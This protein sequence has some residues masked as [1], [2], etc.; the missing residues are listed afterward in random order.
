MARNWEK[1]TGKQVHYLSITDREVVLGDHWGTAMSD[2]AR[3]CSHQDFLTG[4]LQ[5]Q[6]RQIFG[7]AVLAEAL[8]EL[9]HVEAEIAPPPPQANFE[10]EKRL[11][12]AADAGDIAALRRLI[13]EGVNVNAAD[14]GGFAPLHYAMSSYPHMRDKDHLA[15][16]KTLVEAGADVNAATPNGQT[17]LY[18][19]AAEGLYETVV[20][21][22][23]RGAAVNVILDTG[24]TALLEISRKCE[25]RPL[26][27][28]VT[29]TR[30]GK[31]TTLTD[32]EAIRQAIGSHPD[33]EFLAYQKTAAY[34]IQN[35]LDVNAILHET[36]QT[37][38]FAPAGGGVT[39]IAALIL[40]SDKADV[41]H[42]DKWGLTPLHYASRSGHDEIVAMLLVAK[43]EVNA[44][45]E[46]GFTP[47]HE[48][49]EKGHT[50]VIQ[51]LL[52][53]GA[54]KEAALTAAYAAYLAG[55]T[56]ADVARRAGKMDNWLAAV[57][58]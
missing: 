2:N 43:A 11:R 41:N 29:V 47:L 56:P 16:A 19:A 51:T 35:G 57:G 32:P 15:V 31:R 48:A 3:A 54:D 14:T 6:V 53:Y 21:L 1:T 44:R 55:D 38:L 8:R 20:Y 17:P 9:G 18:E 7:A 24:D 10:Q 49:A 12:Q 40:A 28:T 42:Q 37:P 33:D 27:F 25:N 45:D 36:N 34:L 26:D 4:E 30:Q 22:H 39:E 13:S 50:A 5:S 52:G 58:S 46:Y 23:Q